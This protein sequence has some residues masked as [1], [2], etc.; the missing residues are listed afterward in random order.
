M[1]TKA[2]NFKLDEAD[3]IDMKNVAAVFD[4]SV[5]DLVRNAIREYI[6][7][8]KNDPFYRLTM[9]VEEASAKESKEILAKI[10]SLSD[11][12]LTIVSSKKFKA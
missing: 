8:L 4:M 11:D 10:D 1:A 5:T 3:I 2:L 9:N 7:D 12:D 6:A